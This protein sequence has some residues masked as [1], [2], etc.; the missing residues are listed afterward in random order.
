MDSLELRGPGQSVVCCCSAEGEKVT[1]CSWSSGSLVCLFTGIPFW[2]S[3]LGLLLRIILVQQEMLPG[4][5]AKGKP[6]KWVS[7]LQSK[8]LVAR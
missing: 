5:A 6:V 8:S 7:L 4:K 1:F 3:F 2:F